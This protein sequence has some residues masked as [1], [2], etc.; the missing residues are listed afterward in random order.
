MPGIKYWVE[1]LSLAEQEFATHLPLRRDMVAFLTYLRDYRVIGTQATGNLPLKAI[2]EITARF[3]HPPLLDTTIGEHTYRLR[4][5]DDV[6]PLLFVH[7]LADHG[8]LVEGG[9]AKHW[10]LTDDGEQFLQLHP[11]VQIAFL[12]GVWWGNM[13]WT[14]AFPYEGMSKGLPP[15]FEETTQKYL[16]ELPVGTSISAETFADHL[17]TRTGLKWGA[18]VESAPT[19]LQAA[20]YRMVVYVLGY[21]GMAEIEY[22]ESRHS[23]I[24]SSFKI[25]TF[26]RGLL[27]TLGKK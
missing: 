15:R 26:G 17:I 14:V 23:T 16:L 21:F 19:I 4:S 24:V 22:R 27:E 10:R 18:K 25:T 1:N 6:W 12:T 11:A 8:Y 20:V 7:L 13:D 9:Q 2:R 3:A 5:E